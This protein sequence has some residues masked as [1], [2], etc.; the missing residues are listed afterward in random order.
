MV[1]VDVQC[2]CAQGCGDEEAGGRVVC[3]EGGEVLGLAE[4]EAR[5]P[6][7]DGVEGGGV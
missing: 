2:A 5:Y 1:A 3:D 6:A 7:G 4:E